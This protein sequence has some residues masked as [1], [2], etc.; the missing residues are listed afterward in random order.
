M[1]SRSLTVGE[2][3]MSRL[4]PAAKLTLPLTV[5]VP[6]DAPG[7]SVPATLMSA[8]TMPAEPK[9]APWATWIALLEEIT[10]PA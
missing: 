4:E 1:L 2:T 7:E 9:V 8:F 6:G 5:I 3:S 10:L